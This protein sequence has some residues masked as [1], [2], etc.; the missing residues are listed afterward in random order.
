M[1]D[2]NASEYTATGNETNRVNKIATST[3]LRTQRY[4]VTAFI[5]HVDLQKNL[6]GA[7]GAVVG[8]EVIAKVNGDFSRTVGVLGREAGTGFL[9]GLDRSREEAKHE[10]EQKE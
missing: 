9:A 7:A 4:R 2:G 1:C 5:F 6:A 10:A 8:A 3:A